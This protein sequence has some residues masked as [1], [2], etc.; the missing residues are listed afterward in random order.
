MTKPAQTCINIV[1]D[2]QIYTAMTDLLIRS[3]LAC[4]SADPLRGGE[5]P[6]NNGASPLIG[7]LP[8]GSLWNRSIFVRRQC[9][10][11]IRCQG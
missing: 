5:N 6:A 1:A 8:L 2:G 11:S 10:R 7:N 9:F 4:H 3:I